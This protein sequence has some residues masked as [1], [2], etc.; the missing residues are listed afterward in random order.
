MRTT[1]RIP[2][3]IRL[4]S[5]PLPWKRF[6]SAA[7][8]TELNRKLLKNQLL[9]RLSWL[10]HPG[11]QGMSWQAWQFAF[12]T[13][14]PVLINVGLRMTIYSYLRLAL[15]ILFWRVPLACRPPTL[16]WLVWRLW[17]QIDLPPV[18]RKQCG[19]FPVTWNNS[20]VNCY[21]QQSRKVRKNDAHP[22][23]EYRQERRPAPLICFSWVIILMSKVTRGSCFFFICGRMQK[24]NRS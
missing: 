21:V 5:N 14:I 12:G 9:S 7:D 20:I 10:P 19:S 17:L 13:S 24:H 16:S 22:V 8:H 11:N 2:L 3:S 18:N 1:E 23:L 6:S 15:G 4:P